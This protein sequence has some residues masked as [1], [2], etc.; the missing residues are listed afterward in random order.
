ME[1][2][3]NYCYRGFYYVLKDNFWNI[4]DDWYIGE[5]W[6]FN[7]DC[8]R[9]DECFDLPEFVFETNYGRCKKL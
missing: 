5:R 7:S 6:V 3:S 1:K 9:L 4:F 8:Y 2:D